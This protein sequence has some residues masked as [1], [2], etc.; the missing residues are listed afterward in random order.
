MDNHHFNSKIIHPWPFVPS[1]CNKLPEG[2]Q[3]ERNMVLKTDGVF[4]PLSTII[5]NYKPLL[6]INNH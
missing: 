3:P 4:L 5:S 6:S 1:L 2:N